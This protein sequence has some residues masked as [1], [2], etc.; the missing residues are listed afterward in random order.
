MFTCYGWSGATI[1]DLCS[2]NVDMV[3]MEEGIFG[4]TCSTAYLLMVL[5]RMDE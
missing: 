4:A 3:G 2:A 5:E 1:E